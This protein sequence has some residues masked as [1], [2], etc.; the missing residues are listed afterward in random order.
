MQSTYDATRSLFAVDETHGNVP[1]ASGYQTRAYGSFSRRIKKGMQ[2]I[3]TSSESNDLL[4]T[5]YTGLP[6]QTAVVINRSLEPAVIDVNAFNFAPRWIEK[7]SCF[8]ENEVFK[9]EGKYD[10]TIEPG[11]IITLSNVS[12]NH[13][14]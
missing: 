2:R 4:V 9:W 7:S 8:F 10:L 14:P 5:M 11:E 6:G 12:L 3:E 1:K 13:Y